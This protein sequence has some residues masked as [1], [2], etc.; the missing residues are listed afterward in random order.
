MAEKG[1]VL[2]LY[3]LLGIANSLMLEKVPSLMRCGGGWINYAVQTDGYIIPC[4][5]MWG[6]KKYYLGNIADSNPLKLDRVLVNDTPCTECD[7]LG[8]CGGRCLYANITKRWSMEAYAAVCKTVRELV[9]SV[10][11][12]VPRIRRLVDEKKVKLSDFEYV[13]YN[14]CEIIP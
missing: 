8:V 6:M 5:T 14:G 9:K 1:V 12:E 2:R 4:P 10:E 13:K 7:I 3:P 11:A